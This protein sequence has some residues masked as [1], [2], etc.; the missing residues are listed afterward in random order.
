MNRP[1]VVKLG[2]SLLGSVNLVDRLRNWIY[3]QDNPYVVLLT[4]GSP[5]PKALRSKG[6][7]DEETAHWL[8]IRIMTFHVHQL[9]R[10]Y[11]GVMVSLWQHAMQVL[12][13]DQQPF[14]NV[15]PFLHLDDS[16]SDHL[17]H[18]WDVSSD[19][20]APAVGRRPAR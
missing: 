8:A 12:E 16:A 3:A 2:G 19:S 6:E 1:V 7:I 11:N 14:F 5:Y 13:L 20:A 18:T 9:C 4:G 15:G 17:P 10:T